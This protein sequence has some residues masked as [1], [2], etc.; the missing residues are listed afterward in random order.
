MSSVKP[1]RLRQGLKVQGRVIHALIIR[2]LITRFGRENIG[3][4]WMMVEPLLFAGLVAII[5]R[6]MRGSEEHGVS[7]V[8]FVVTGY[9]PLTLFRHVVGRSV[10][11]FQANSSLMYHRQIQILDFVI[12][13]FL[14][15]MLGTMMAFVFIAT[16]LICFDAF[17]IPADPGLM[18]AGWLVYCAFSFSLCLM[19]APLSEMSEVLEKFLPVTTYI[20]IPFSGSF[21]MVSWLSP[22]LR[23]Y[24]LWSPFV[25]GVEMM[26]GGIWGEHLVV[27]YDVWY[28]LGVSMIFSAIGLVLIR[29]VRRKIVVE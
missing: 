23:Q 15:E 28:P 4:L 22:G 20:M 5:W 19:I 14:I 21:T 17:P 1:S 18:I 9:I 29:R 24:I 27:Y 7:I 2:E 16:I 8:A 11:I 12:V 13:R 6:M 10:A 26:R 3:F 25:N